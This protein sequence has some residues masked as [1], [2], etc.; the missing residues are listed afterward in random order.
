[1]VN[2]L[3]RR[4]T[5]VYSSNSLQGENESGA[6]PP[7]HCTGQAAL[8]YL[9]SG[10][11]SPLAS[12]VVGQGHLHN[13]EANAARHA[14]SSAS[15]HDWS[16]PREAALG[17]VAGSGRGAATPR[18]GQVPWSSHSARSSRDLQPAISCAFASGSWQWGWP[19]PGTGYLA[20]RP[21]RWTARS[22]RSDSADQWEC[23]GR[24]GC[25]PQWGGASGR[26]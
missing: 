26:R 9:F 13:G 15:R 25:V 16:D 19:P 14:E 24:G 22:T 2:E 5:T 23:E 7:P 1:M 3:G 12:C 6:S 20:M 8:I 4:R 10:R 17:A 21:R 18:Q 11:H